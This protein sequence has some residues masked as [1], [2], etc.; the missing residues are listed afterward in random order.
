ME[1]GIQ[2]KWHRSM[3]VHIDDALSWPHGSLHAEL[4]GSTLGKVGNS[5]ALSV[6]AGNDAWIV[7]RNRRGDWRLE[8][9]DWRLEHERVPW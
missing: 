4:G 3:Y 2:A 5:S 8:I 7:G 9:G 1:Q 6:S